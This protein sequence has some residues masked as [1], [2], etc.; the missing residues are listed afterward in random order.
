MKTKLLFRVMLG[1]AMILTL[2]L[3]NAV[4]VSA[5]QPTAYK[6][7]PPPLT[8]PTQAVPFSHP[9]DNTCNPASPIYNPADLYG[10]P[11]TRFGPPGQQ[12]AA[13]SS[14]TDLWWAILI[15]FRR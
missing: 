13:T 5:A 11:G 6:P 8:D 1:V 3:V 15:L 7:F 9:L 12:N 2:V 4:S 14:P 10:A